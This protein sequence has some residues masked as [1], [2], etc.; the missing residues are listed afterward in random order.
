VQAPNWQHLVNIRFEKDQPDASVMKTG[1]HVGFISNQ[2]LPGFRPAL[3]SS[4]MG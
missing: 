1:E 4:G 3:L 2:L